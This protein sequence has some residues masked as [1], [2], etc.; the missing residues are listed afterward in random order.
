MFQRTN[1]GFRLWPLHGKQTIMRRGV[2]N[3]HVVGDDEFFQALGN[4][5]GQS[6]LEIEQQ[7]VLETEDVQVTFHLPLCRDERGITAFTAAQFLDVVRHLTMETPDAIRAGQTNTPAK[8]QV[9]HTGARAQ[10]RVFSQ[11]V[12]VVADDFRAVQFRKARV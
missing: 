9:Q 11:N 4:F 8:T 3:L 10:R 2:H 7:F 6:W 1:H 12:A 5:R